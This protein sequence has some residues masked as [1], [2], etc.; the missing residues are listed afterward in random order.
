MPQL[1]VM[2]VDGSRAFRTVLSECVDASGLAR[3]VAHA[4][5]G[6][7]ALSKASDFKPDLATL[8]IELPVIS[9]LEALERLREE[10]P[11]IRVV[12]VS[13][14]TRQGAKETIRALELGAYDF[15]AKPDGKDAQ[16][17]K[18][19]LRVQLKAILLGIRQAAASAAGPGPLP[20]LRSGGAS[21]P[22][23]PP[24]IRSAPPEIV[25][26]GSSTGGP[27]ALMQIVPRLP[28]N[29]PVPLVITQH[30]PPLFT[31]ALAST[32]A[33]RS[34]LKV[35]EAQ[36]GQPLLA[37][38]VY[39]APGGKQLRVATTGPGA[40]PGAER[41]LELTDDPPE[42][43][44]RPAVDYL[45]RSVAQV[46]RER[47]LGVILTGMGVDGAAGLREMKRHA[48]K[49]IGQ[50]AASCTVYGMPR[51]AMA[52]GVVDLELPAER[53]AA[54]ITASVSRT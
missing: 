52:A 27:N 19:A 9:G 6:Q 5:D 12:M 2:V 38:T 7:E 28:G 21:T 30:M 53:I 24:A 50:S 41:H 34:A 18:E 23:A 4:G 31:A 39:F 43:S 11:Q 32:L 13:S 20:P 29:L 14:L 35:V 40:G 49:V 46:Y 33:E 45:F 8:D 22:A 1:R 44:C 48:V 37:G 51:E 26:I 54:E 10:H 36:H 16:A 3:V 17:N 42:H 15:L 25:A 47:A